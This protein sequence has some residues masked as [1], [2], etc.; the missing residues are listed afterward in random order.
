MDGGHPS[1][2]PPPPPAPPPSGRVRSSL[3]PCRVKD[4]SPDTCHCVVPGAAGRE[5]RE[6]RARRAGD[7]S[8]V[9]TG[10]R[11]AIRW[12][13]DAAVTFGNAADDTAE[14]KR[15]ANTSSSSWWTK[16]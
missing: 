12:R 16:M 13:R 4:S 15:I 1:A 5:R 2:P 14:T 3:F 11:N 8:S 10:P 7:D 9:L 6:R